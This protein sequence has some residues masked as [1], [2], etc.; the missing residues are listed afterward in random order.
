MDNG[1]GLSRPQLESVH[2]LDFRISALLRKLNEVGG[3]DA[4]AFQNSLRKL[5]QANLEQDQIDLGDY[6]LRTTLPDDPQENYSKLFDL[7]MNCRKPA[8]VYGQFS[9]L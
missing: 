6:L 5:A 8:L 1:G 2:R 7:T 3:Q 4:T 9:P